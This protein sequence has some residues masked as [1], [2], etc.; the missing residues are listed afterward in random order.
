MSVY[1]QT[2]DVLLKTCQEVEISS[3]ALDIEILATLGIS[4]DRLG[5]LVA[6]SNIA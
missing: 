6:S 5:I 4:A 1:W 2:N 3:L